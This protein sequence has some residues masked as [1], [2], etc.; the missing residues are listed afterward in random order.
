MQELIVVTI[1]VAIE[2]G[3]KMP[4][5]T[6]GEELRTALNRLGAIRH[7]ALRLPGTASSI[8]HIVN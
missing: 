2:G 4:P 8:Q 3:L 1:I 6:S 5:V 7:M